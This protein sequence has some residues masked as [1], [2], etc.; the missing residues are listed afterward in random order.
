M[1]CEA[2]T[3]DGTTMFICGS[4][5]KTKGPHCQF[6]DDP[7]PEY[8]CDWPVQQPKVINTEDLRVGDVI[9]GKPTRK[10]RLNSPPSRWVVRTIDRT[11]P[12]NL[13]VSAQRED[14]GKIVTA[15]APVYLSV[16]RTGTCDH[17]VCFR[18]C[19]E[20]DDDRHYCLTHQQASLF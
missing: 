11:D 14:T 8:L 16:E 2:L 6:C 12:Y 1:H 3:I 7:A 19:R 18:H 5:R 17:P 10:G 9:I 13:L 4:G 15:V 20:V